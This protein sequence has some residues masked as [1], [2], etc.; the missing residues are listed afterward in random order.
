MT[1]RYNM[2]KFGNIADQSRIYKPSQACDDFEKRQQAH[3]RQQNLNSL[4]ENR[5]AEINVGASEKALFTGI[6]E[7][8]RVRKPPGG[9]T[10]D[11]FGMEN[12]QKLQAHTQ[13]CRETDIW[14]NTQ[15][16]KKNID[17]STDQ[18]ENCE[19]D[20][21]DFSYFLNQLNLSKP[22]KSSS[23]QLNKENLNIFLDKSDSV[24]GKF[25]NQL[26]ENKLKAVNEEEELKCS[27]KKFLR[28]NPI[29]GEVMEV[30]VTVRSKLADCSNFT[31]TQNRA[32]ITKGSEAH[33]TTVRVRQPPGG[34]SSNIF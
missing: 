13:K 1:S 12:R 11:I 10:N 7:N 32:Q 30:E 4:E 21:S 33:R 2:D 22:V 18:D 14:N 15:I 8:T 3:M 25:T 17:N 9:D 6:T 23:Y 29:T 20:S 26:S 28:R 27:R 5:N 16:P 34:T 19:N 31:P 24:N